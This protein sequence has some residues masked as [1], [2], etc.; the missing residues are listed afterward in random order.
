MIYLEEDKDLFTAIGIAVVRINTVEFYL[1]AYLTSQ[2]EILNLPITQHDV[3]KL[4]NG[5]FGDALAIFRKIIAN[6]Q[7]KDVSGEDLFSMLQ[8]LNSCR[9]LLTH[10]AIATN[11][12]ADGIESRQINDKYRF[13]EYIDKSGKVHQSEPANKDKIFNIVSLAEKC[14]TILAEML[15]E[16]TLQKRVLKR[17]KH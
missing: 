10:I 7:H 4:R 14:I 13:L 2:I 6:I 3:K 16:N 15:V 8:N 9:I 12:D 5:M 11:V 1:K 17:N